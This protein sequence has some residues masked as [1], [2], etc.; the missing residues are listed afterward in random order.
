MSISLLLYQLID[1]L[2]IVKAYHKP[3]NFEG[4]LQRKIMKVFLFVILLHLI[5]TAIFLT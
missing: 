5:V 1:K 4:L 3:L 2:M